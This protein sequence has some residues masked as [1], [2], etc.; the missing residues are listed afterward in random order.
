MDGE[1]EYSSVTDPWSLEH[2]YALMNRNA[3][4]QM[5]V[6]PSDGQV[7]ELQ[8]QPQPSLP[9]MARLSLEAKQG[10]AKASRPGRQTETDGDM[11]FSTAD[12]SVHGGT[13]R[14]PHHNN[15]NMNS[16]SSMNMS[17]ANV[18]MNSTG[19]G[20]DSS[21]RR[22][23]RLDPRMIPS[24]RS[25]P[26]LG[27]PSLSE[28]TVGHHT[29]NF[30][31]QFDKISSQTKNSTMMMRAANNEDLLDEDDEEG[32]QPASCRDFMSHR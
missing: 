31:P 10:G 1:S 32:P 27:R 15:L 26:E 29:K 7:A 16:Q 21:R 11:V 24:K 19:G 28:S 20:D 18:E 22:G 9:D 13:G 5:I 14:D 3:D 4:A 23:D 8:V 2:L 30:S 17:G 25:P 6:D 12:T